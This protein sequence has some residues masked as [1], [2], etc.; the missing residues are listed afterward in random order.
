[1][2]DFWQ[3]KK[4]I[5][6]VALTHHTRFISPVMEKLAN[7]GA[8]THYIIGQA[9]RS[10]EIT[11]I[12]L[13]LNY[14]H[15]FDFVTEKDNEDVQNNYLLLRD[16]FS[17]NLKNNFLF[18]T[19]PV[20]VI[21]KTI[22]STAVEYIGFRNLLK[23]EKPDLCFALH[24][25]NRWGKLFS[26]WSK[27]LGIPVI[28]FQE[29]LYSGL[30][31]FRT[32]H[33]QNS[34]L[35]LVWGEKTKKKLVDFEAPVDRIIPVGNTHLSTEIDFQKKNHIRERKRKQYQ[36]SNSFAILLLFSGEL[37][38][39]KE[40]YPLF[41]SVSNTPGKRLFIKFHP[42]TNHIQME[43][44]VSSI[45]DGCKTNIKAF[46]DDENTYDLMS[47]SDICVLVQ[48]STTGLEALSLG[49]PLVHLD[50][51][52]KSK[53]AYS[54]T[55]FNVAAKMTPA[56]L[57]KA[58]SENKDFSKIINKDNIKKY[59]EN[60]LSGTTD[61]IDR[62][63]D[64]SKKIIKA[65][66]ANPNS[67]IQAS[68]ESNKDWSIIVPL[69]NRAT[70]ILKQL[71]AIAL[72]SENNG[73][74]EVILIEPVHISKASSD[75][76]DSLKGDVTRLVMEPGLSIP[77]MLNKASKAATGKTLLF[78]DKNL[79]PLPNWLYYL[80]KGIKKYGKNKILG[81]RIL[82]RRGSILHAGIIIDKNHAPVSAYK[83]LAGEFPNAMKE[84]SFKI[85]DHFICIDKAFFHEIG[86]FW[87]KA[88]KFMFMD[89][90][91]RADTYKKNKDTCIY[92]P[93][94]CM[95]SLNKNKERFNP[96][97]SIYFFGKWH[98]VLWENQEKFYTT[99]K[100][101][102]AELD[103]ARLAQSMATA[104]LI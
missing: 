22:Y 100:I 61:T 87:K 41:K 70:D 83:Y 37:P 12:K 91:L 38:S 59:L 32:G 3:N 28:T 92:I 94:A 66:R 54:F 56:E 40:L 14:S 80:K 18:G 34:T 4:I 86:G 31:F 85:F 26:F 93:D 64:I 42:I 75:I 99:D 88:G 74:F 36:C 79:L 11:A 46:H 58:I 19:S 50:V 27:K 30:D 68:M 6:Y 103:A 98:G 15:I 96:D 72:N 52:M 71:E 73:T 2:S 29:G 43:R 76:L 13:G 67:P 95:V 84:R 78:L 21:D 45:P 104:N 62:V 23:Q 25:L 8:K 53:S 17:N 101:S 1:M 49:K 102:K 51:N 60:E 35:N 33:V 89:L 20:T 57:G 9:E 55:E 44:W 16:A 82:D 10:Q 97:D 81:T 90:C 48:P 65:S 24:E 47:L 63:T 39:P 77:E 69:S 7:Q 5:A